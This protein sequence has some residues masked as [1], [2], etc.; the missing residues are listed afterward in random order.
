MLVLPML[1]VSSFIPP[2]RL[3]AAISAYCAAEQGRANE[4]LGIA[5]PF[6]S[7]DGQRVLGEMV[8]AHWPDLAQLAA[9]VRDIV[10]LEPACLVLRGLGYNQY[11]ET[12]R[13]SLVLALTRS[14]GKPT[15]HNLDKRV[16]WPVKPR[17]DVVRRTVDYKTTFS[18][19]AGEAPLHS[20]SAFAPSPEK[21]NCLFVVRQAVAGGVSVVLNVPHLVEDLARKAEG[22]DCLAILRREQFP[23]R[24]PD[25]FFKG[26]RVITAP[27]LGE[28]PFVRFR[29]DCLA[30]GFAMREDLRSNERLWAI[31]HFRA[32]AENSER[33]LSYRLQPDE[34][35]V[36]DNHTMLHARTDFADQSRHLIRVR[37][38]AA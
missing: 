26:K 31:E 10:A 11:P 22:R 14:I 34:A 9:L 1:D 15:D 27:V 19:E 18:E 35:L 29:G 4:L 38:H 28:E 3:V 12:V 17:A 8:A 24:V 5:V 7:E 33:R 21:Y 13:D 2:P 23:F 16:L 37:M 30:A 6:E 20:D 36:L 25:A 32:A